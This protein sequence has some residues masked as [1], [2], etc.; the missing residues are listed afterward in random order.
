ML[1]QVIGFFLS[2][3]ANPSIL[4]IGLAVVF[5]AVWLACYRPP[6]FEK[7][8]LWVVL[9]A[10]SILTLVGIAFIQIPL[11]TWTGQ[12]LNHLWSQEVLSRWLLLA[13]IPAILVGGLVQ[14]G[15]KFVPVVVWWWRRGR[16]IDPKMGLLIGAVSGVG[17]G[18]FEAQWVHNFIFASG[19]SWESVQTSGIVALGGFWERLFVVGYHTASCALAGWGLARGW[20]WQFYLLA[21][22]LHAF[23]HYSALLMSRLL[24]SVVQTELLIAAWALLVIGGALWLREREPAVVTEE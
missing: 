2:W 10:S 9:A 20:G 19:W 4:G 18:I 17:F 8:W 22:F 16:N 24:S 3:F 11:Q 21:S 15:S 7:P 23:L 14:E 13:G 6:L 1:E 5:G 12:A